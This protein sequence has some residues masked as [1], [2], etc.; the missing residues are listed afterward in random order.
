MATIVLINDHP[1]YKGGA[2]TVMN[3]KAGLLRKAGH[4]LY[5][6]TMS[7]EMH[8][9]SDESYIYRESDYYVARKSLKYS[10][11]FMLYFRLRKYLAKLNPDLIILNLITKYPAS[12]Y[13]AVRKYH[14]I[15]T[16]HGPNL[17]CATGWGCYKKTYRACPC[18]VGIKCFTN[19]CVPAYQLPLVSFNYHWVKFLALKAVDLFIT[20]TEHLLETAKNC[21]FQ[22]SK[23]IPLGIGASYGEITPK[24]NWPNKP[25]VIFAGTLL[26]KKGVYVLLDAFKLVLEKIPNAE[27]ILAGRIDGDFQG[28]AE[29]IGISDSCNFLG[30]VATDKMSE[31]YERGRCICDAKFVAG[32]IRACWY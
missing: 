6:F 15:Q 28:H 31:I 30:H 3:Q 5:I 18:G 7:E 14:C 25:T 32:A 8:S 10:F 19:D 17:F 1:D 23:Y 27:L 11:N 24:N 4:D 21:G 20:P 9:E 26:E 22:K 12:V 13:A 16:L 29:R 2:D